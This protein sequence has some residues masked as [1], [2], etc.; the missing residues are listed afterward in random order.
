MQPPQRVGVVV[1]PVG[2]TQ[3]LVIVP[4]VVAAGGCLLFRSLAEDVQLFL[5]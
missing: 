3:H 4:A 2:G 5:G 1:Q